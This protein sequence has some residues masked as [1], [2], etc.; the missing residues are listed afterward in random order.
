MLCLCTQV[1]ISTPLGAAVATITPQLV[2]AALQHRKCREILALP[3]HRSASA[4]AAAAATS[5]APTAAFTWAVQGSVGAAPG[6]AGGAEGSAGSGSN[7]SGAGY[8]GEDVPSA[9]TAGG[10]SQGGSGGGGLPVEH[11]QEAYAMVLVEVVR[12]P[13]TANTRGVG[14]I[15]N[16]E[17]TTAVPT[18]ASLRPQ[19]TAP[20]HSGAST[21]SSSA[22]SSSGSA[23]ALSAGVQL[24][25]A[26]CALLAG[27]ALQQFREQPLMLLLELLLLAAVAGTAWTTAKRS[28]DGSL[29]NNGGGST[30]INT[31]SSVPT[32][33]KPLPVTAS[34]NMGSSEDVKC[35]GWSLVLMSADLVSS[36]SRHLQLQVRFVSCHVTCAW[37]LLPWVW[38]D[39]TTG[40]LFLQ[41]DMGLAGLVVWLA[42]Q[43]QQRVN[44]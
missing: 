29:S 37:A 17:A 25:L 8:D 21:S 41:Y 31:I 19:P 39:D 23:G 2:K 43:M 34:N 5:A 38:V 28:S 27:L 1:T 4:P 33:Q 9:F 42:V 12:S 44:C 15:Y 11:T 18:A 40:V 16:P 3:L 22:T 10:A 14:D 35:C 13:G 30:S 36:P 24:Q 6:A 26:V 7:M 20:V 32:V